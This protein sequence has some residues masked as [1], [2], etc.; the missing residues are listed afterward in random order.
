[1]ATFTL[2][3]GNLSRT[4]TF[5]TTIG[6]PTTPNT[7]LGNIQSALDS[8]FGAKNTIVSLIAN[9]NVRAVGIQF[10]GPLSRA[11]I[12]QLTASNPAGGTVITNTLLEGQGN[13]VQTLTLTGSAGGNSLGTFTLTYQGFNPTTQ[14]PNVPALS[15]VQ[16]VSPTAQD[17]QN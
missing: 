13:T 12:L 2:S 17:V 4:V 11:N 7:L 1:N 8:M 3:Y 15:F 16:G 6:T 10:T 14:P 5:S 9:T